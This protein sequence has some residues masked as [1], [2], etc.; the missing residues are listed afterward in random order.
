[1]LANQNQQH[2]KGITHYDQV[3]FITGV[4]GWSAPEN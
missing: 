2:I 4:Q 3:G 1:M